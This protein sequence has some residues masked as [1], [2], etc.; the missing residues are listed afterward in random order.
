MSDFRNRIQFALDRLHWRL[1]WVSA[2]F[3]WVACHTVGCVPMKNGNCRVGTYWHCIWCL[4]DVPEPEPLIPPMRLDELEQIC[5][6]AREQ[7][8]AVTPAACYGGGES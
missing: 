2:A 1:W 4:K 8:A 6:E 5:A 3:T 7:A